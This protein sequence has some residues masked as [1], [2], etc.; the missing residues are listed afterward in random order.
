MSDRSAP[1]G[2][3]PEPQPPARRLQ[4]VRSGR[5][6]ALAIAALLL[7]C[8]SE[9][10]NSVGRERSAAGE[11]RPYVRDCNETV[12]GRLERGY[13]AESTVVAGLT[14]VRMPRLA[15]ARREI[16]RAIRP[17]PRVFPTKVLVTLKKGHRALVEIPEHVTERLRFWYD[18]DQ[19]D[20]RGRIPVATGQSAVEFVACRKGEG[21][22]GATQFNGGLLIGD[23]GCFPLNISIDGGRAMRTIVSLGGG[24]CSKRA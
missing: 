24:R 4:I 15:T 13:R 6:C 9:G 8:T 12:W 22:P 1:H 2:G 20:Q 18:P 10:G 7:S 23:V 14:F 3:S 16:R 21:G 17:G 19:W 11:L 5:V